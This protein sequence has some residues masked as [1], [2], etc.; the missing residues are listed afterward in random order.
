MTYTEIEQIA[1]ECGVG[2]GMRPPLRV[3]ADGK[4]NL[5]FGRVNEFTVYGDALFRFA[6]AIEL[7]AREEID[8]D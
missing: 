5:R 6:R 3:A 8:N 7:L 1:N 4:G 2:V